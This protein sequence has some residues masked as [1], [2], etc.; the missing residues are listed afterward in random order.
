M[1]SLEFIEN[2]MECCEID[3]VL[4][5]KREDKIMT[6]YFKERY[7]QL[8]QIKAK[9][10]AWEETK[11]EIQELREKLNA[12]EECCVILERGLTKYKSAI[13]IIKSLFFI[14]LIERE[15]D[16]KLGFSPKVELFEQHRFTALCKEYGNT[17]KK[18]L[19][20]EN[21]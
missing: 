19:E 7:E 9:L 20:V 11:E 16:Y 3:F 15:N 10:E 17:I 5:Q 21:D 1:T 2:E 8:K 13:E 6:R 12:E 4:A 18:A 14:D